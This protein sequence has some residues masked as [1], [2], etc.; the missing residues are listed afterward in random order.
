MTPTMPPP[1]K[2]PTRGRP[3]ADK[4]RVKTVQFRL[5]DDEW[6]ATN[7]YLNTHEFPPEVGVV[8]RKVW[9]D[10]LAAKGFPVQPRPKLPVKP[11]KP[12]DDD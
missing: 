6:A 5:T 9:L 10:F 3:K 4:P 11:A 8:A 7:A 1:K 2:K 12:A